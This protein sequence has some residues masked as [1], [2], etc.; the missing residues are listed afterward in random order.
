MA[1]DAKKLPPVVLAAAPL[2]FVREWVVVGLLIFGGCCTNVYTL[3]VLVKSA[4]QSG[5]LITFA[6]FL[7]VA[8]EGLISNLEFGRGGAADSGR[9]VWPV[10]L[11]KRVI[12]MSRWLGMVVLFLVVSILN[13]YALGF[14]ISM[15]VHIIFR[16]GSLLVSMLLSWGLFKKSFSHSQIFGVVLVTIGI[17]LA[18]LRT[19]SSG[20]STTPD[21][22]ASV[23]L[24]GILVL[25]LALVLACFLGQMQQHTYTQYGQQWREGLFYTHALALPAFLLFA[26]DLRRQIQDYNA[27][28]LVSVGDMIAPWLPGVL[29]RSLWRLLGG[30]ALRQV[31]VPQMWIYLTW[32]VLTQY[33]CISG[34]HK[35]SSMATAVTLNL[36]SFAAH[37]V[38]T[39][40]KFVSLILSVM[41][42][43]NT[44]TTQ[45]W[46]GAAAVFIGT[47]VYSL[48]KSP[49]PTASAQ[50]Q[51]AEPARSPAHG[52][53]HK[54]K[55]D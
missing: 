28:P 43:N 25:T 38:L 50:Q 13:N 49:P 5:N 17:V 33:V 36:A 37:A 7:L 35:L 15:P 26:G 32:N 4:P 40:R 44:F 3:E 31:F 51:G 12:P 20:P 41:L 11:R 10:R 34:V 22:P 19:S 52:S 47:L 24:T 55:R 23:W 27:S 2:L 18:T 45:N 9:P 6:Q 48:S 21:A 1:L 29:S 39:V 42:F 53:A 54:L 46:I 30:D 14:S 8:L 16:S